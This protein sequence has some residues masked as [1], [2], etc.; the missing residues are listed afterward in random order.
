MDEPFVMNSF[1]AEAALPLEDVNAKSDVYLAGFGKQ[2][3]FILD[4]T[5]LWA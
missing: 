5:Y 1:V 3:V 2:M 4:R